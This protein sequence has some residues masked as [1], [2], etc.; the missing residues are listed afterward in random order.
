[1]KK[2]LFAALAAGVMSTTLMAGWLDATVSEIRQD[3]NGD[4]AIKATVGTNDWNKFVD[5]SSS[6]KKEI[7]TIALTAKASGS[8]VMLDYSGGYWVGI[9]IK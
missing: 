6:V 7:L 1:M 9:M 3:S 5:P 8:P 2:M 4:I